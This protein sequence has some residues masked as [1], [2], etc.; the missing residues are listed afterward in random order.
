MAP[1]SLVDVMETV[2]DSQPELA[3]LEHSLVRIAQTASDTIPRTGHAGFSVRFPDGHLEALASSDA[4]VGEVAQLQHSI[5]EGPSVDA[6]TDEWVSCSNELASDPHWPTYGPRASALGFRSQLAM[7][8]LDGPKTRIVLNLYSRERSAFAH[9]MEAA[10]VLVNHARLILVSGHDLES[11]RGSVSA[12]E[13]IGEALAIV[14]ERYEMVE[15]TAA[16]YLLRLSENADLGIRDIAGQI[17]QA[18]HG[19]DLHSG[20]TWHTAR[21]KSARV[22][23]RATAE[24]LKVHHRQLGGPAVR[25]SID[26]RA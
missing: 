14:M 3:D 5:H 16:D 13:H 24:R 26:S 7:R 2:A 12:R 18:A 15:D 21:V 11:M 1:W 20:L 8:V 4:L 22:N 6:L 17:L 19:E 10:D 25:P 23:A 9:P